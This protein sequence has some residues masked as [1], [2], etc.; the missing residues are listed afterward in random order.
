LGWISLFIGESRLIYNARS[1]GCAGRLNF[2]GFPA[3]DVPHCGIA[4]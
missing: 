4:G 2:Q 3:A 1:I